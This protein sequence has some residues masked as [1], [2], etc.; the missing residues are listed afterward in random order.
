MSMTPPRTA[1]VAAATRQRTL[2]EA[3]SPAVL[4]IGDDDYN[5]AALVSS[6]TWELR[7][8]GFKWVI[9]FMATIGKD[10]LATEPAQGTIVV[11]DGKGY[12][13]TEVGGLNSFDQQWVLR[14]MRVPGRD[15]A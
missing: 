3:M 9:R 10:L 14:G 12:K 6:A 2:D 13:V 1:F 11:I 4:S 15:D 7:D 8:G 5:G